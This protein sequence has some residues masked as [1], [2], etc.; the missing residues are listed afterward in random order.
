MTTG[1]T[2]LLLTEEEIEKE[3][4]SLSSEAFTYLEKGDML[5]LSQLVDPVEGISF[6]FYADFGQPLGKGYGGDYVNLLGNELIKAYDQQF[7]WGYD[8]S[9]Q[10]FEMSLKDYIHNLLLQ[11]YGVP[12]QYHQITYNEQAHDYGGVINTIHDNYPSAKYVE[13]FGQ[14]VSD[15]PHT[16]QSIRFVKNEATHGI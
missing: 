11:R 7:I 6:S 16:Y 14:I 15:D 4:L 10:N 2:T 13:Y 12:I 8:E 9:E 5:G 1:S 3:L